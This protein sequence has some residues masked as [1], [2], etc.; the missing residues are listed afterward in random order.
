MRITVAVLS[1]AAFAACGQQPASTATPTSTSDG[2]AEQEI[3]QSTLKAHLR[4]LSHDLMEGRAPSTRGGNLAAEY[5]ATQLA[6]MGIEPAGE[7][8]SYFQQVPIV[9]AV[10]DRSFTLSVPGNIYRYHDDVVAFSG[11]EQPRAHVQGEVVFVGH[12]I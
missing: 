5:L 10:V 9:E 8:G 6:A 11:T 2:P 3:Q 4:M 7:N 1:L 12:G